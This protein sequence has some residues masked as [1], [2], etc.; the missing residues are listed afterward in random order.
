MECGSHGQ[1]ATAAPHHPSLWD[2]GGTTTSWCSEWNSVYICCWVGTTMLRM[3][4]TS[5]TQKVST[6]ID[7]QL[8]KQQH[9]SGL[10]E[11]QY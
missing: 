8:A 4:G 5:M 6:S 11:P 3:W 1:S 9:Q 2:C 7:I 10:Q